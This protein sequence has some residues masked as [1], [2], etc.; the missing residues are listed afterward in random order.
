MAVTKTVTMQNTDGETYSTIE[1]WLAAYNPPGA[2]YA[3]NPTNGITRAYALNG[4]GSVTCT[5]TFPDE[6]TFN[7]WNGT[8]PDPTWKAGKLDITLDA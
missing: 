2:Q 8:A 1:A 5:L 7:T 6:A 4:D 3:E